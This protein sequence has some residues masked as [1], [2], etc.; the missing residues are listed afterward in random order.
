MR[1]E[2]DSGQTPP[3]ELEIHLQ[4]WLGLGFSMNQVQKGGAHVSPLESAGAAKALACGERS[5]C[6]QGAG[7][8]RRKKTTTIVFISERRPVLG[9]TVN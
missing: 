1:A 9:P 8:G 5:G 7:L 4:D 2:Q 6:T 3:N